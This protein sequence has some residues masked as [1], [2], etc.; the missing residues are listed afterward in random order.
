MAA[1]RAA[2]RLKRAWR[3]QS[4]L[5]LEVHL[6]ED[7]VSHPPRGRCDVLV[8]AANEELVGTKLPYFPMAVEPPPEL[9]NSKW[10]AME[11]GDRM[12]YPMQVVDGR[13]HALG[14]Q[15]L[16]QACARL[17]EHSP[18]VRCAI[19][20][21]VVTEAYGDLC[22]HFA[23][24]VHTVPPMYQAKDWAQSLAR[25]W[26]TAIA[27]A[28]TCSEDRLVVA[29]PLLGAGA[30]GAP[31]EEAAQVAVEALAATPKTVTGEAVVCLAVRED[32]I[33]E[34]LEAELSRVVGLPIETSGSE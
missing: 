10:C 31:V 7:I 22:A 23:F 26:R 25:C 12:F 16:R 17:P 18:G 11:I 15:A 5:R 20:D 34:T 4:N 8:N 21:A 13:V 14:G 24:I 32:H 29:A 28:F 6:T 33:A 1:L 9:R 3:L 19:G 2:A 30:R 27:Q